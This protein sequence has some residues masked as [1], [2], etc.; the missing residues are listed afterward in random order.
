M[1]PK[2]AQRPVLL[3]TAGLETSDSPLSNRHRHEE[4]ATYLRDNLPQVG[5]KVIREV[6]SGLDWFVV[7]EE[8]AWVVC[9]LLADAGRDSVIYLSFDRTAYLRTFG[10]IGQ[11][12]VLGQFSNVVDL[13]GTRAKGLVKFAGLEWRDESH[14]ADFVIATYPAS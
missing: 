4:A 10:D 12:E 14:R 3:F 7:P 8:G 13:I 5:F 6:N 1:G 2:N 11:G 9:Q